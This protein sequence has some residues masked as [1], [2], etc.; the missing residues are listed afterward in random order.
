MKS[1]EITNNGIEHMNKLAGG[2]LF[3]LQTIQSMAERWGVTRQMVNNW[4]ERHDDFPT[5][6]KGLITE[7]AKTP[8]V[9][10]LN[11]V[12]EYEKARG[13]IK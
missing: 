4:S 9:Y 8:N 3:P 10:P 12:E 2:R 5:P 1:I 6:L 11:E 13:I 7:T